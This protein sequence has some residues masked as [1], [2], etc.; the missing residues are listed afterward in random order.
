MQSLKEGDSDLIKRNKGSVPPHWHRGTNALQ[1]VCVCVY[2]CVYAVL[3]V[4][5][6]IV[7]LSTLKTDIS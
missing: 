3:C 5:I 6:C 7:Q 4:L 1:S 2:V